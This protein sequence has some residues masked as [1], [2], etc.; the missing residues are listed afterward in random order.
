MIE[1]YGVRTL[2]GC[3]DDFNSHNPQRAQ[4]AYADDLE[5][6]V[7]A[8]GQVWLGKAQHLEAYTRLYTACPDVHLRLLRVVGSSTYA[9]GEWILSGTAERPLGTLPATGRSFALRGV[10]CARLNADGVQRQ[11][12]Y[13]DLATVLRQLGLLRPAE[14]A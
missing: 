6:L 14:S 13:W 1:P 9:A 7:P 4:R 5:H 12:D 11:V 8:L 2:R 10:S 3:V